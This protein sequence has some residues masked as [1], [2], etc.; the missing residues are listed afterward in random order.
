[1]FKRGDNATVVQNHYAEPGSRDFVGETGKVTG[2]DD[3]LVSIRFEE[4]GRSYGFMPEE[5][6]RAK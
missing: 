6:E 4:G 3:R 1:M 2:A 5:V